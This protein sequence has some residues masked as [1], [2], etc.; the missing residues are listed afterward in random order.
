MKR[1]MSPNGPVFLPLAQPGSPQGKFAA[2]LHEHGYREPD[3]SGE[4]VAGVCPDLI[5]RLE[6]GRA[7]VFFDDADREGHDVL[8]DD[9]WTVIL[10]GPGTEWQHV[11]DRYP[12]V[13]GGREGAL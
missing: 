9:G 11:V 10:L 7:A 12:S 3:E 13:F 5:Y 1:I 8:R 2:W 4:E 6:D